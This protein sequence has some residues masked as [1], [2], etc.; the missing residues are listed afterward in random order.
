MIVQSDPHMNFRLMIVIDG[1]A[2]DVTQL[3]INAQWSGRNGSATRQF[4]ATLLDDDGDG[5]E[6]I[7]IDVMRA[8]QCMW[9][10]VDEFDKTWELFRGLIVRTEQSNARQLTITA[11]DLG[12][13]L[14]NNKDTFVYNGATASSIFR[15]VCNRFGI[16]MG[17]VDE[18][19]YRIP[20]EIDSKTSG[21]DVIAD[22]LEQT[23]DN[24]GVRFFPMAWE[25]KMCLYERRNRIATYVVEPGWNLVDYSKSVSIEKIKTRIIAY[26]SEDAVVAAA[27]NSAVE[28]KLGVFQDVMSS[29]SEASQG[30]TQAKVDKELEEA[31][32]PEDSFSITVIGMPDVMTG[33]LLFVRIPHLGVTA[34]YYVEEDSHSW[35]GACCQSRFSMTLATDYSV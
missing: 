33:A 19:P 9:F 22:A 12:I 8:D 34:P 14:A 29:D 17:Q 11:N 10:W 18:T 30:E 32:K 23:V 20:D 13:Y 27:T 26:D 5:H 25:G 4:Q 1:E 2:K 6:R 16:P 24:T 31:S 35:D 3:L 7:S 15:D 21:W 28:A